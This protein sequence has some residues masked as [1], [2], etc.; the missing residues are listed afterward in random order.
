[1]RSKRLRVVV[2]SNR[3]KFLQSSVTA[4]AVTSFK[5]EVTALINIDGKG[6]YWTFAYFSY[7]I[8]LKL[9]VILSVKRRN[10][11]TV[12][13]F[14]AFR[15]TLFLYRCKLLCQKLLLKGAVE[16]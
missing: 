15:M 14:T 13:S 4:Y 8:T 7:D 3:Y 11:I 1:M 6:V 12:R 5:K 2:E 10:L 16:R 9:D